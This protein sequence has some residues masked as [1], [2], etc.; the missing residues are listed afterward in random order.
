MEK[1]VA[2][3]LDRDGVVNEAVRRGQDFVGREQ[4]G[5]W[6]HTAPFTV[7][8]FRVFPET[9]DAVARIRAMG[10][11]S[12]VV[13]NQ[14]DLAYGRMTK[15]TFDKL[16]QLTRALGFDDVFICPHGRDEG[17][18][19][20]KPKPGMLLDAARRWNIDLSRSCIIGDTKS[21]TGAG[22]AA[23]CKTILI[24][25][26]YNEEDHATADVV[27]GSLGEA[28]DWIVRDRAGL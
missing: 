5:T 8:E 27:V 7:E 24:A 23:G 11:L 10:L 12:I 9:A 3:F 14:P 21:D 18:S 26:S 17:C 6:K 4:T 1:K 28:I 22:K 19:C 16:E 13:T 20:K 2:V 15:D 25:R